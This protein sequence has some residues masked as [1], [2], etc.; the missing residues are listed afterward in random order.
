MIAL[1]IILII[2]GLL[3]SHILFVIGIILLAV[4]VIVNFLPIGGGTHRWY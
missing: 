1:G 3:F 2:L 4:G